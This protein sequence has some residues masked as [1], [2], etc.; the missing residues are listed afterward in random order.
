MAHDDSGRTADTVPSDR[1]RKMPPANFIFVMAIR[2]F[3]ADDS[4][5]HTQ[6]AR[7]KCFSCQCQSLRR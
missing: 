3:A 5:S 6:Y 1:V 7:H 4:L 2:A